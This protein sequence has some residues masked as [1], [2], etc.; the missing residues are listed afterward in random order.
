[1]TTFANFE[2][3]GL[4]GGGIFIGGKLQAFTVGTRLNPQTAVIHF[5][6]AN[7]DYKGLSQ[8]VNQEF[9][10]NEWSKMKYI[11][12]EQDLGI[13]GLRKAKLSYHP[14]HLVNKYTISR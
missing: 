9:V 6:T 4:A 10:I 5:E 11:N 3:L 14:H 13:P 8:V 12:R 1:E 7:P 2:A